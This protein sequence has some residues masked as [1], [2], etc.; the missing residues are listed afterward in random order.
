LDILTLKGLIS[1]VFHFF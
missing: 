1:V